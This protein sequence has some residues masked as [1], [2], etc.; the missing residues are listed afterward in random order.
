[1]RLAREKGSVVGV[2]AARGLLEALEAGERGA[3]RVSAS[4]GV[5]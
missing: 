3:G 4:P 5:E 1:M 2:G